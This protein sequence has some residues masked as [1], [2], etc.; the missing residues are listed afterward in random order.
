MDSISK[1]LVENII[2]FWQKISRHSKLLVYTVL[3][4]QG[5]C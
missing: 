1:V 3:D 5:E 2:Y 4:E